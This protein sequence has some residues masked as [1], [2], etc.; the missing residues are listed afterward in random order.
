MAMFY[1]YMLENGKNIRIP[2]NTIENLMKTLKL[3]EEDAIQV[4]LEDEGYEINEEQEKL[5]KKAKE[6]RITAT[7]HKAEGKTR[8]KRKVERRANP[9]KEDLIR[10]LAEYLTGVAADVKVTNIGK[11]I[12]F[13]YNDKLFKLDLIETRIKK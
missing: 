11:L 7:I 6:N 3:S 4:Y 13:K 9:D 8:E 1:D 12:E 10:G 2:K 5:T